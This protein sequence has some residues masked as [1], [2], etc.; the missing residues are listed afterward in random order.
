MPATLT[1]F[2]AYCF[3]LACV[4]L[5]SQIGSFLIETYLPL[6]QS[7][8]LL[9]FLKFTHVR[10]MGGVFGLA[11]GKGWIFAGVSSV[12]LIGLTVFIYRDK[13]IRP[14]EYWCYG[15]IV[16]GGLSNILDRIIYGSVI[17]FV[18]VQGI[19]GWNYIFN[20]A[21]VFIHVGIWPIFIGAFLFRKDDSE[22]E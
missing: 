14:F 19:P 6:H 5:I 18:D 7:W 11:Q 22:K 9:P 20:T 10:N 3:A 4:L 2:R 1:G 21:D 15:S 12:L 17:D 13:K 8:D 16:G